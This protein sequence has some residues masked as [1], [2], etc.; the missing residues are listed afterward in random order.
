[1]TPGFF[2]IVYMEN[3]NDSLVFLQNFFVRESCMEVL[4]NGVLIQ[5]LSR[6]LK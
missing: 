4:S 3:T 5:F 2:L 1:M 6:F